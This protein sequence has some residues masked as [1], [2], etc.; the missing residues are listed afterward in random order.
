MAF[1]HDDAMRSAQD[2]ARK[3]RDWQQIEP[4]ASSDKPWRCNACSFETTSVLDAERHALTGG[5]G[6]AH[7][8]WAARGSSKRGYRLHSPDGVSVACM[9]RGRA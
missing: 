6:Y 3:A 7:I 4:P 9:Q 8:L 5:Y 2:L 1:S